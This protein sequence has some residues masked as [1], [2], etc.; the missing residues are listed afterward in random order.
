LIELIKNATQLLK[1]QIE[2]SNKGTKKP[3]E[4]PHALD[5][6]SSS[7]KKCGAK[8]RSGIPCKN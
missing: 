4:R 5:Q 8:T 1:A 6:I 7:L 3:S 2:P